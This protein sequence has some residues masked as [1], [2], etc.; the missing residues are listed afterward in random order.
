M[1]FSHSSPR[2]IYWEVRQMQHDDCSLRHLHSLTTAF[3]LY[4]GSLALSLRLRYPTNCQLLWCISFIRNLYCP[5]LPHWTLTGG[6]RKL[7]NEK[8]EMGRAGSMYYNEKKNAYGDLA[9]KSEG[10]RPLGIPMH[11]WDNHI[12]DLKPHGMVCW[13]GASGIM[14]GLSGGLLWTL[15]QTFGNHKMWGTSW[16]AEKQLVSEGHCCLVLEL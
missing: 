9:R 4:D 3:D 11:R 8:D 16:P 14:L 12:I 10:Q 15:K 5:S 1:N 7:H 13:L 2:A 6:W